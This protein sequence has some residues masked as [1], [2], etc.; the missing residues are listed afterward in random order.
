[1]KNNKYIK[2]SFPYSYITK[3]LENNDKVEKLIFYIDLQ[4]LAKGFY[5]KDNIY[6][7]I[8]YYLENRKPSTFLIDELRD[9]LNKIYKKFKNEY[10]KDVHFV[11]FYDV[12]KNQQNL[13]IDS[14]YKSGRSSID[15]IVQ[16]Q[17]ELQLYYDIKN[18]YFDVIERYFDK[19]QI[20][21]KI[22]SDVFYLKNYESDLIPYFY[23]KNGYRGSLNATTMNFILSNDKDLL[24]CCHLSNTYQITNNF[25]PS[26]K[27]GKQLEVKIWNDKN[28]I[29][30]I[31]EKFQEGILTSKFIPLI[32]SIAGDK[33]DGIDGLK[34]Y[35]IRK[36]ISFIQNLNLPP[37]MNEIKNMGSNLPKLINDNL[38]LI[39]HNYQLIS[40]EEQIKRTK[41]LEK[42]DFE[43][44]R[45]DY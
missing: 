17:Q 29:A 36:T 13:S 28:A 33:S 12:G 40:F 41:V 34:G 43:L 20:K 35:G 26:Q 16:N 10:G 38:E 9:F 4:S 1:M 14:N 45:E 21:G 32:L 15:N 2:Y 6:F 42:I 5:N 39:D 25:K 11:I 27:F 23:I 31:D 18:N 37:T 7:E 19:K 8:N 3:I 44:K 22:I 30:Y 24:Q